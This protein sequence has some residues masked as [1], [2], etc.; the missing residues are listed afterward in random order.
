MDLIVDAIIADFDGRT[1]LSVLRRSSE[2]DP[3]N[4]RKKP[5]DE[6]ERGRQKISETRRGTQQ[7]PLFRL[8]LLH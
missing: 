7:Q 4:A 5:D 1:L 6:K 3:M 2:G 8:Q